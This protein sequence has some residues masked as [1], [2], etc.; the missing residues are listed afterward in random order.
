MPALQKWQIETAAEYRDKR[1]AERVDEQRKCYE[2]VDA[3]DRSI[4]RLTGEYLSWSS[5]SAKTRREHHHLIPRSRG[6]QHVTSNV[7]T[8]SAA[9]HQ[10][11][12]A[13]KLHLSGDADQRDP[14]GKL[15]GVH[16]E[17]MGENGWE[18]VAWV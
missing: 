12:H 10:A 15:C 2:K 11:I 4:C 8:I 14:D 6:G 1:K 5:T 7:V 18:T 13:G 17:R 3:R 16:V 9:V